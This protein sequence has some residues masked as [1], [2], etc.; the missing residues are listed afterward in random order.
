MIYKSLDDVLQVIALGKPAAVVDVFIESYLTG[1]QHAAWLDSLRDEAG[2]LPE[3]LPEVPTFSAPDLAEWRRLKKLALGSAFDGSLAAGRFQCSL[4][5]AIDCRRSGKH[6]DVGNMERLLGKLTRDGAVGCTI[7]GADNEF[8][9]VTT[10]QLRDVII[11][12]MVDFGFQLYQ[13]KWMTEA[14]IDFAT[15]ADEL[16]AVAG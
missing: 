15:S 16:K 13:T 1:L 2:E 4:G 7:R 12:E 8:H 6:D 10:A 11:P 14:Q 3:P 5:W 9:A